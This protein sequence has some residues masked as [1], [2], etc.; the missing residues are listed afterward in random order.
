[1]FRWFQFCPDSS[2]SQDF[3]SGSEDT[4]TFGESTGKQVSTFTRLDLEL[5]TMD[6][7][8]PTNIEHARDI[9]NCPLSGYFNR[10]RSEVV[11]RHT[12]VEVGP[13]IGLAIHKAYRVMLPIQHLAAC[14][15]VR[16]GI[17]CNHLSTEFDTVAEVDGLPNA[18]QG[19]HQHVH[20]GVRKS[21]HRQFAGFSAMYCAMRPYSPP[22]RR[23]ARS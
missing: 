17:E 10:Q 9:Q 3:P 1:M 13:E 7:Q 2:A 5:T 4:R 22:W 15:R 21:V 11:T 20:H 23:M 16:S 12:V 8:V 6:G 19:Q 14:D 18:G